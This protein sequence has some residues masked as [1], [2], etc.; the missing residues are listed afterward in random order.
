MKQFLK[1]L[2]KAMAA[3]KTDDERKALYKIIEDI[4]EDQMVGHDELWKE[5]ESKLET[6]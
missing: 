5:L 2:L 1:R 6:S 4:R 3:A